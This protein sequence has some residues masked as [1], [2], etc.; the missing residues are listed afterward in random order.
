VA[1]WMFVSTAITRPKTWIATRRIA[2]AGGAVVVAAVTLAAPA[3]ADTNDESFLTSLRNAGV[4]YANTTET[5]A[6]GQ[7]VC[8]TLAAPR[9]NFAETVLTVAGNS[10]GISPGMAGT[11]TSLAIA[12]YCPSLM[13]SMAN[14]DW[15]ELIGGWWS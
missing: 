13:S 5:V 9:S 3:V 6:L 11:F 7:S 10:N 1:T 2:M 8:S 12:M 4:G 14:G 15:T